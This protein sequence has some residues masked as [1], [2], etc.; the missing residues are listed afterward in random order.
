[1]IFK[2]LQSLTIEETNSLLYR[3]GSDF[4]DTMVTKV[5]P[6]VND[7]RERGDAAVKEY[8]H[9]FDGKA[10]NKLMA[11][12]SELVN[13]AKKVDRAIIDAFSKAKENIEEFHKRQIRESYRYERGTDGLFG[14]QYHPIERAAVYAPGGKALYP[15]SVLMGIIPAQIAGVK[16]ITLIT[17]VREG[18]ELNP[19]ICAMCELLGIEKVLKVGGAQGIA[20]AG[21]G[22]ESVSKADIIVGPGNVFVTSAKSYLFSLGVI[23]IDSLAGPSETVVISDTS[24]DPTWVAWDL[25]SQAEHEENARAVLIDTSEDHAREVLKAIEQDLQTNTGRAEIKKTSVERHL[26]ILIADSVEEAITFSNR[27]APEHLQL[28]TADPLQYVDSVKNTGSL[29]LG[30]F[31]PVAAGDYFSG[32]NHVLPTGGAARFS[33]GLSVDTFCRRTTWQMLTREGLE[34]AKDPISIMSEVEGFGDKHGGSVRI[35]FEK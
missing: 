22:T 2:K 9:R 4:I 5:V 12:K 11:E 25:L 31:S 29:F 28:M 14:A 34:R 27:Y 21:F 17:P 8:A 23:Q 20:A 6:I 26:T 18:T 13:G 32:T 35:R 19:I 33:S 1:M 15:S 24:V 3:F 7:V 30:S 16:E 10:P